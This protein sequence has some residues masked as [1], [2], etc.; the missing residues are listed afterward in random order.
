MDDH[1]HIDILRSGVG[2]GKFGDD[3]VVIGE[4]LGE[5]VVDHVFVGRLSVG[6]GAAEWA[7]A[8]GG[9]QVGEKEGENDF[10]T[11]DHSDLVSVVD[12]D[13]RGCWW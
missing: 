2:V 1:T 5:G 10:E 11:P 3:G 8:L 9:N 6:V 13:A 12:N 7:W 4:E